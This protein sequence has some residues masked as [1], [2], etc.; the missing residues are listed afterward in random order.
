M[1]RHATEYAHFFP[2]HPIMLRSIARD[3]NTKGRQT[4]ER[5]K[6]WKTCITMLTVTK[7][8]PAI[9]GN[10]TL[11]IPYPMPRAVSI[12]GR[13]SNHVASWVSTLFLA[14]AGRRR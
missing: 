8:S 4:S 12:G 9:D 6:F 7:V 2:G 3:D 11:L 1:V 14:N 10:Y 13:R 5:S